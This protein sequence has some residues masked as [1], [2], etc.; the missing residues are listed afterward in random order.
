MN[1]YWRKNLMIDAVK[2][3]WGLVFSD[4]LGANPLKILVS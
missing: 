4:M 2:A 1:H 3:L